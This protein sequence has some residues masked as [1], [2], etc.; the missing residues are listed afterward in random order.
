M[1]MTGLEDILENGDNNIDRKKHK[2]NLIQDEEICPRY[3]SCH[4]RHACGTYLDFAYLECDN[5]RLWC[6]L[7]HQKY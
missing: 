2:E 5:Y 3:S 6:E 1:M 7:N 4:F